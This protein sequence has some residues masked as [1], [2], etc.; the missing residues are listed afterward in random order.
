MNILQR[1]ILTLGLTIKSLCLKLFLCGSLGEL[2]SIREASDLLTALA[3]QERIIKTKMSLLVQSPNDYEVVSMRLSNV[4]SWMDYLHCI[5][6][7]RD[8]WK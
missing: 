7:I 2:A 4:T 6:R 3:K 1:L 8:L 5:E